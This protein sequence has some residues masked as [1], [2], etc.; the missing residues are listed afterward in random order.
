MFLLLMKVITVIV[1]FP[2]LPTDKRADYWLLVL[3]VTF[4]IPKYDFNYGISLTI[5]E[6][7]N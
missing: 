4:G 7:P 3:G 6:P 1:I 5:L 2:I